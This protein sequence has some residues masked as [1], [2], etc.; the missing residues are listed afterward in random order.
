M[1]KQEVDGIFKALPVVEQENLKNRFLACI[2]K[3]KWLSYKFHNEGGLENASIQLE[4]NRFL[5]VAG[6]VKI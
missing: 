4:F 1:N 6:I 2:Q 5:G 3:N